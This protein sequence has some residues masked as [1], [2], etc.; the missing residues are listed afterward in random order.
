MTNAAGG[1][2]LMPVANFLYEVGYLKRVP[3]TGWLVAGVQNPESIAEHSFRAAIIGMVLAYLEGADPAKTAMLCLLHDTQETRIGDVPSV[4]KAYVTTVDNPSVTADQVVGFPESLADALV[5]LV[6]EYEGRESPEAILARDADK[7]E[8]LLQAREYLATGHEDVP[9]WIE[10]SAAAVRSVSGMRLAK[11][12]QQSLGPGGTSRDVKILRL[13]PAHTGATSAARH[14]RRKSRTS[15]GQV[16]PK[17][18]WAAA[19]AAY[20]RPQRPLRGS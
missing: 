14:S 11:L 17:D 1:G 12:C 16:A 4:G 9:P 13:V 10:T 6:T 15:S 8:C 2:D 18:W 5:S 19:A 3:R 7:L 20:P